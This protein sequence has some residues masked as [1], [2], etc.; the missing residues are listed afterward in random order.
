[1]LRHHPASEVLED[2]GDLRRELGL[3]TGGQ[4][5]VR[6]RRVVLRRA[7]GQDLRVVLA[8]PE[9]GAELSQGRQRCVGRIESRSEDM[10]ASSVPL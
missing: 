8:E 5:Q 4:D 1:M 3:E 6:R 10:H 2:G 7:E 9:P